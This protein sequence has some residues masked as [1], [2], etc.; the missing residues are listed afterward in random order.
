ML[1]LKPVLPVSTKVKGLATARGSYIAVKL[2]NK[3]LCVAFCK[4]L[5][6]VTGRVSFS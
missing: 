1:L 3:F 6:K 4:S 5:E 2:L